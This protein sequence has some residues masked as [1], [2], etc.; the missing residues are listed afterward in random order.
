MFDRFRRNKVKVD[1]IYDLDDLDAGT[2]IE[3]VYKKPEMK[4]T[5][6]KGHDGSIDIKSEFASESPVQDTLHFNVRYKEIEA[7]DYSYTLKSGKKAIERFYT[8]KEIKRHM[9]KYFDS[10]EYVV[11]IDSVDWS[12]IKEHFHSV[13]DP[14]VGRA[15]W[16]SHNGTIDLKASI[17]KRRKSEVPK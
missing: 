3:P 9:K 6:S 5:I 11:K 16:T 13:Y 15:S 10:G 17:F 1:V 12:D 14:G 2:S 8:N 4:K 7:H